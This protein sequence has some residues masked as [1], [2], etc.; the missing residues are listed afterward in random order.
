M[1]EQDYYTLEEKKKEAE[2][3]MK[4]AFP[5]RIRT[6]SISVTQD[7]KGLLGISKRCDGFTPIELLGL[8]SWAYADIL[9]QMNGHVQPDI[10][11]RE[12]VEQE[13]K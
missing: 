12:F 13:D 7:S 11:N 1:K 8:L 2:E 4:K 3:E 5:E 10:V 9:E 6:Y